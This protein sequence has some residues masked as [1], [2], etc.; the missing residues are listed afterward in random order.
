MKPKNTSAEKG[1][2]SKK[3]LKTIKSKEFR[4]NGSKGIMTKNNLLNSVRIKTIMN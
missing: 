4:N 2:K 3:K 1:S